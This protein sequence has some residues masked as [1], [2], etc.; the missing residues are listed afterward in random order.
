MKQVMMLLAL[1]GTLMAGHD[2]WR[3][4]PKPESHTPEPSTIGLMGAGL[5]AL[6]VARNWRAR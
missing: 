2:D 6:M 4:R 5:L 1:S 3:H